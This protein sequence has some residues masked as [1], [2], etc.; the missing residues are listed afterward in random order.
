MYCVIIPKNKGD[1]MKKLVIASLFMSTYVFANQSGQNMT[2]AGQC[3]KKVIVAAQKATVLDSIYDFSDD[4][5]TSNEDASNTYDLSYLSE[6]CFYRVIVKTKPT[7][8]N[9]ST[10][11]VTDCQIIDVADDGD[12]NCG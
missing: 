4:E 12:P 11:K 10:N 5:I 1:F 9:K 3:K 2:L 6:G 8:I 7:K